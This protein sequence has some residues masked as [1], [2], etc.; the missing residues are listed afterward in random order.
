MGSE[1]CGRASHGQHVFWVSN[2]TKAMSSGF[3][4]VPAPV[5]DAERGAGRCDPLLSK[6]PGSLA[7]LCGGARSR[8]CP[9]FVLSACGGNQCKGLKNG[10]PRMSHVRLKCV[11]GNQCK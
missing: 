7:L 8:G 3:P 5:A 6:V 11:L 10:L 9:T 2:S 1:K 4:T